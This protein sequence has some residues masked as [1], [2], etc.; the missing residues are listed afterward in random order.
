MVK[1]LDRVFAQAIRY[2]SALSIIMLDID[3]FKKVNDNYGHQAGDEV[4]VKTSKKIM[5]IFRECDICFHY[6]GEEFYYFA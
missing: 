4:L 3:F 6:G 1:I 5:D 2:K